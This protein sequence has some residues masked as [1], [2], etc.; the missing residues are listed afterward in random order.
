MTQ[1][2]HGH[3]IA[4]STS[5]PRPFETRWTEAEARYLKAFARPAPLPRSEPVLYQMLKQLERVPPE[6]DGID[7]SPSSM[8]AYEE[9]GNAVRRHRQLVDDVTRDQKKLCQLRNTPEHQL[10][11]DIDAAL[12][13]PPEGTQDCLDRLCGPI[14]RNDSWPIPGKIYQPIHTAGRA[15]REHTR[16]LMGP[17]HALQN[18]ADR[19]NRVL[20]FEHDEPDRQN[21]RL[22]L[23]LATRVSALTDLPRT[24]TTPPAKRRPQNGSKR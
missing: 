16:V 13:V 2:D 4:W 17:L 22:I 12:L 18:L 11:A 21:R 10:L 1:L 8:A 23:A 19:I 24:L 5:D 14:E 15:A 3:Q 20:E 7:R 6:D 9:F